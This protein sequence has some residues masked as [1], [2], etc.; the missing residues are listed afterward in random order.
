MELEFMADIPVGSAE[1]FIYLDE[2]GLNTLIESIEEART[3]G[4]IHLMSK[5]W[6]GGEI[7]ISR[8]STNS[9]NKVTLTFTNRI[10][11]E[12]PNAVAD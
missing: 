4:H 5:D 9:F 7:T 2:K 1:L 10:A 11:K 12:S 8:G 6:G 3:T